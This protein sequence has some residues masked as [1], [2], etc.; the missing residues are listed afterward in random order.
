MSGLLLVLDATTPIGRAVVEQ[1]L[2]A[3]RPVLAASLDYAGLREIKADHRKADLVLLPGSIADAAAATALATEVQS[4][5][6]PLSAVVMA[7]ACAPRRSRLLDI[8]DAALLAQLRE[9]VLPHL[10][11][12][13]ML[14]PVLAASG[15]N[16]SYTVIG[17]PGGEQPWAGY[18]LRSVAAAATRMLLRVL[19]D[20]ARA[21]SVRLQLLSVEM[22]A[23]TDDNA[24]HACAHWPSARAIAERALALSD[25]QRWRE[26]A[27][28]VVRF[29]WNAT[30]PPPDRRA[31]H[32]SPAP[33][34]RLLDD[35]WRALRPL[36]MAEAGETAALRESDSPDNNDKN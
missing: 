26:P 1:A 6:R 5:D 3:D 10:A 32:A 2:R 35:T 34:P 12:A 11:A 13:R 31:V 19:H 18:G 4:L 29:A 9:E 20:E 24:E 23:R 21:L 28:A 22:P 17:G 33:S 16:G 36:L 30:P 8:D 27:E 15:R 25:P 14:L 7:A